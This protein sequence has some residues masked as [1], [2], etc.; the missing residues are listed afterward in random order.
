MNETE[1]IH[2]LKSLLKQRILLIDGA[3]GTAIQ[4]RGLGPDD[5]GGAG[6]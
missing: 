2:K 4:E 3:M 6:I 5:F 1:R